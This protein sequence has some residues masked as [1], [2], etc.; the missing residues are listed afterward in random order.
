MLTKSTDIP[1]VSVDLRAYLTTLK[2]ILSPDLLEANRQLLV[3]N[4]HKH[5]QIIANGLK[6][7]YVIK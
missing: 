3:A 4:R 6:I 7:C 2:D 5:V 1:L